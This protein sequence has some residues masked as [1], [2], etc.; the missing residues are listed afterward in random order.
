VTALVGDN[1]AGKSTLVKI[2]CGADEPDDGEMLLDGRSVFFQDP[3][4]ARRA[5]IETVYQDLSIA[6]D[7]DV[8]TNLFLG[9]E[10]IKPGVGR[11][12]R[13]V[14]RKRM[15]R[16]ARQAVDDLH[17]RVPSLETRVRYL[18]GG[19]RQGVAVARAVMWA[20]KVTI[21]DEPTAALGVEQTQM[22]L[23]LIKRVRNKGIAVLVVSHSLPDVFAVA[24]TIAVLRHGSKVADLNPQ[25]TNMDEVVSFMTGAL[26][27]SPWQT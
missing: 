1:G 3:S 25:T 24:D 27:S 26:G 22:V 9:R 14:D 15:R 7:L 8:A 4:D 5:G 23:N 19:Q 21:M 2:I 11:L 16:E 13:I 12:L 6:P 17:I 10:S 18:S 20:R